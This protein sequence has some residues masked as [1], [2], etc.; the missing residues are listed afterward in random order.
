MDLLV[1][2]AVLA[3]GVAFYVFVAWGSDPEG[4]APRWM[5][6]ISGGFAALLLFGALAYMV[7]EVVLH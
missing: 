1:A 3:G 5:A 2:G 4:T 7:L 6:T